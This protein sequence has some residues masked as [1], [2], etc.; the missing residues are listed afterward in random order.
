MKPHPIGALL[1]A[2]L[3]TGC[4][5]H[6]YRAAPISP[7]V[8]AVTLYS[9]SLDDPNLEAWM[10][11]HAGFKA[12]S[13][14]LQA[15]NL[16]SLTLAAYY[17]NPD[18][19]VARA[20]A[21]ASDAAITTAAMKP[22]PSVSVGPGYQGPNGSQP[23]AAFDFSLPIET[24]GKRGYRIAN[25]SHLSAASRLQLG[26]TAW[27]VR[28]RVRVTLVDYLFAVQ[29]ADLLRRETALRKEYVRLTEA[30]FQ[31]GEVPLPDL[32][33]ARIDLTSLRQTLSTAEGQVQTTHAALA[34]AI[35]VPDSA[36]AGKTLTLEDASSPP[37]PSLLPSLTVRKLA[38]EN[39]LDVLGALE[40]Y[41][42][43]QSGLQ[44]EIAKQY[45]DVNVGPGYS[46]EEGT[47]FL[48]LVVSSVLPLRTHNEGPIAEA[49]AQR[50][51]AGAQLLAAQSTVL[52]DVDHSQA[53]YAAA[54]AVLERATPAVSELKEQERSA[55]TLLEAGETERLTVVAAQLLTSVSERARLDALHQAQLSLGLVEDALQRPLGNEI[56]PAFPHNAPRP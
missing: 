53:Q 5:P 55:V 27:V 29:A 28:S 3:F 52:A 48:S 17:F 14:A 54:F 15:W 7:A 36:L 34:A 50:K 45:P 4:A 19:D 39:R 20:N 13:W 44:L 23:I 33:T 42:A 16:E 31:A 35:G 51:L 37:A 43:A 10:T 8:T 32:T 41:G 18:L 22:N 49:E 47:N 9:H 46:Y 26:Q 30:R 38:L 2:V 24:A 1:C 6:K 25:A 21:S 56:S 11:Q 40:K 12:P